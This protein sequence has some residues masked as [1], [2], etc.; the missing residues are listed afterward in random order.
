VIGREAGVSVGIR[1]PTGCN[2]RARPKR[3]GP[4]RVH[5]RSVSSRETRTASLDQHWTLS[6]A[7]RARFAHGCYAMPGLWSARS[8]SDPRS[9]RAD[10]ARCGPAVPHC[11]WFGH[12]VSRLEHVPQFCWLVLATIWQ[13]DELRVVQH[14]FLWHRRGSRRPRGVHVTP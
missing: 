5:F 6:A 1:W 3:E 9:A 8:A 12:I 7:C 11:C 14:P 10:R 13:G 2:R 4:P